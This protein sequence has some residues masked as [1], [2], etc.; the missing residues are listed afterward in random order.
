MTE[1]RNLAEPPLHAGL[2]NEPPSAKWPFIE[3]V[4]NGMITNHNN[5]YACNEAHVRFHEAVP[6]V[7]HHLIFQQLGV[8]ISSRAMF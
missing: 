6:D 4:L 3:D 7:V 5:R 8:V 2:L 1:V